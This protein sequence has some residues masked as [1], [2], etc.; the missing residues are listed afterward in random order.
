MRTGVR[1]TVLLVN[2]AL[3]S[4]CEVAQELVGGRRLQQL[5]IVLERPLLA[6]DDRFA[7]LSRCCGLRRKQRGPVPL[8]VS[9][10]LYVHL[11]NALN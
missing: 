5:V 7:E 8:C 2:C 3:E 1:P 9:L 6:Q 4:R 11:K 10:I